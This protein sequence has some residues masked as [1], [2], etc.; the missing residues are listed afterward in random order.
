MLL[1]SPGSRTS[2][3]RR[4]R[5]RCRHGNVK[6]EET[7]ITR[8]N[9][10]GRSVDCE[11]Q[12]RTNRVTIMKKKK[13]SHYSCQLINLHTWYIFQIL[14]ILILLMLVL[15]SIISYVR[16]YNIHIHIHMFTLLGPRDNKRPKKWLM[17][18][19][20]VASR[21]FINHLRAAGSCCV[22]PRAAVFTT[23]I[24]KL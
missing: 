22:A 21:G 14:L 7:K 12:Q 4:R 5:G 10:E 8:R 15:R 3:A 18:G 19:A 20:C 1:P 23:C 6:H 13:T 24:C 16:V 17:A 2:K 11:R 9:P